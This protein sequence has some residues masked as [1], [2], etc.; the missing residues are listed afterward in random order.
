MRNW[1][2]D[3]RPCNALTGGPCGGK[4]TL[5]R[6]LLADAT[7]ADEWLSVPE[8]APRLFRAGLDSRQKDFEVAVVQLQI[9]IEDTCADMAGDARALICHRGTLDA[10][11][12]WLDH[13]WQQGEFFDLTQSCSDD[14][15]GRYAG[16]LHLQSAAVGASEFYR[17]WPDAH[18]SETMSGAAH[19]DHLCAFGRDGKDSCDPA[20][21]QSFG[22]D[23]TLQVHV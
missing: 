13:G 23:A 18:R 11:A 22:P 20:Q 12:Y 10:L 9:A 7:E 2:L 16:V 21:G 17:Q 1:N 6:E 15:F 14:H 4:S 5:I 19:I 8:T 3:R